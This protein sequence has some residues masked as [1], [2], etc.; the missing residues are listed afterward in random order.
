MSVKKRFICGYSQI[1][2]FCMFNSFLFL[3]L[4]PDFF[5]QDNF[6][7]HYVIMEGCEFEAVQKR[8][9]HFVL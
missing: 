1:T 7:N 3:D 2:L 5:N 4:I 6:Y 8:C 9:K